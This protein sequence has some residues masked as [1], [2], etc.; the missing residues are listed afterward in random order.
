MRLSSLYERDSRRNKLTA[1]IL[2]VRTAS[3]TRKAIFHLTIHTAPISIQVVAIITLKLEPFPIP[4]DLVTQLSGWVINK[5]NLTLDAFVT[6][7]ATQTT[8][9]T[10]ETLLELGVPECAHRTGRRLVGYC[11]VCWGRLGK[12]LRFDAWVVVLDVALEACADVVGVETVGFLVASVTPACHFKA[13]AYALAVDG[14]VPGETDAVCTVPGCSV[15]RFTDTFVA[16]R[17]T[18]CPVKDSPNRTNTPITCIH[19]PKIALETLLPIP[20]GPLN[21]Y[22]LHQRRIPHHIARTL[23]IEHTQ[24]P[25]K[26]RPHRTISRHRQAHAIPPLQQVGASLGE[27]H[28]CRSVPVIVA[29]DAFSLWGDAALAGPG[30]ALW[31][32]GGGEDAL[33]G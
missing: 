18:S 26:I 30:H 6:V 22:T 14:T 28:T 25:I 27:R 19:H 32:G 3:W 9:S 16:Q 23:I 33:V 13:E 11:Y 31:A 10:W 20:E 15:H 4:T 29:L 24:V 5:P 8:I 2:R 21:T 17:C 1:W 12:G 7:D